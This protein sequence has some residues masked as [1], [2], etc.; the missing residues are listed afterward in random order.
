MIN[1][2]KVTILII[3]LIASS[4]ICSFI[5]SNAESNG[6][7]SEE[8]IYNYLEPLVEALNLVGSEYVEKNIDIDKMVQEAIKGMLESLN[9][10]YTRYMNPNSLK[11]EQEDMFLGHFGG[12][13]II[14][15]LKDEQLTI[16][17]PINPVEMT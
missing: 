3:V 1:R 11:R 16:I 4:I 17:S 6:K 7:Y 15:S 10:P 12:L 13:G 9:D 14:I 2:K 8:E 5:L